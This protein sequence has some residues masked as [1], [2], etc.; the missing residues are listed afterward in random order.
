MLAEEKGDK[1]PLCL[2]ALIRPD[3]GFP[4][5]TDSLEKRE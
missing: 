5:I 1:V 4:A 3:S 2:V